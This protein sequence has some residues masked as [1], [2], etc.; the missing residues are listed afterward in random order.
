MKIHGIEGGYT[1][2][3]D[4]PVSVLLEADAY[5]ANG[6]IISL[7]TPLNTTLTR[8]HGNLDIYIGAACVKVANAAFLSIQANDSDLAVTGENATIEI[9]AYTRINVPISIT[10]SKITFIGSGSTL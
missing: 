4:S 10:D 9:T 6:S 7:T 3:I 1:I 5:S 2:S 8:F